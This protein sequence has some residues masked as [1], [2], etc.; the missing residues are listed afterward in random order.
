MGF[1]DFNKTRGYRNF[2]A[3]VYGIGASIV[4]VG[5][6]F[7][8]NHYPGADL[9]LA[10][11][12]GTEALIF[13][14]SAFED[15]HVEPDWSLVYP[16]LAGMYHPVKEIESPEKRK[17]ATKQLDEMLKKANIEQETIERLGKGLEKLS[18][19]TAQIST[20]SEAAIA[21]DE[22]AKK[23]TAAAEAA[24][25]LGSSM[26]KDA[27]TAGRYAETMNVVNENANNL[28]NAYVQA[29]DTLKNNM[30]STETFAG[31]VKEA[32]QSAKEMAESYR[33]SSEIL[34]KS[35]EALDF[36]VVE[37]DAYNSQLRKIAENLAALNAMY[38]IQLKDSNAMMEDSGKMKSTLNDLYQQLEKSTVLTGDFAGQMK[39]LTERMGTLNKVYGNM[40]TAMNVQG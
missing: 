17:S 25:T 14:L 13:L 40:L 3:K 7:K 21:S 37:G 32:T 20:V 6:L 35:V 16:E 31:T 27:E 12:L 11:G 38:E 19:T 39:T 28:T 24:G 4:L 10:I 18:E 8:I 9:M 36:T 26:E 15:P 22:F 5:A 34:S 23:M 29:A 30:D 1:F 2:M 33:K